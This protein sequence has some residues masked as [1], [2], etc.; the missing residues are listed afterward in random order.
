MAEGAATGNRA[1]WGTWVPFPGCATTISH[2]KP[3]TLSN[4]S[5]GAKRWSPRS[6]LFG[7]QEKI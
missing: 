2:K 3:T 6:W 7:L 5:S 4:R 1:S